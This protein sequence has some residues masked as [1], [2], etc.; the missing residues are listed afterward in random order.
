MPVPEAAMHKDDSMVFRKH[1]VWPARQI[2]GRKA[3]A[4][5]QA[6]Q[7]PADDQFGLRIATPD[8]GHHPRS[9]FW[10]NTVSHVEARRPN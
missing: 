4:E 9:N 5:T 10:R 1:H 7:E 8:R 2:A 6:V 3:V